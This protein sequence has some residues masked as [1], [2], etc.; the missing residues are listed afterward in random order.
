MQD[1]SNVGNRKL[2]I[3]FVC[4]VNRLRSATAHKIYEDDI[5]F[6]VTS[7]GTDK[8]AIT[9]ISLDLLTWADSIVVMEK[10]HRNFIRQKFP[11]IYKNKKIVCLYIPDEYDYMQKELIYIIKEKF[12]DVFQRGLLR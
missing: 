10:H 3:L 6:E 9:V 12:E 7:A 1:L 4:T 5:R 2:K 8:R 11:D